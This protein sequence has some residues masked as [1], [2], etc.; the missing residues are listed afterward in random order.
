M[1]LVQYV[2]MWMCCGGQ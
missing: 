2:N 1:L